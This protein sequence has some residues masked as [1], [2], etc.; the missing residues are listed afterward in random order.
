MS[1]KTKDLSSRI[2]T[3]QE[4]LEEENNTRD[5]VELPAFSSPGIGR[6]PNNCKIFFFFYFDFTFLHKRI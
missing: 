3:L 2:Q 4:R 5:R 1:A 6:R